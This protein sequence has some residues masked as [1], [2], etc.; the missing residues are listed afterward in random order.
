[1]TA[2]PGS[3]KQKAS[4]EKY[5]K[6]EKGRAARKRAR[7]KYEATDQAKSKRAAYSKRY[8][9]TKKGRAANR[10]A[11]EKYRANKKAEKEATV[12]GTR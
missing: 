7:D 10:L 6:T 1:M 9:K 3:E 2:K 4:Y 12:T 5:R 8:R 11:Q